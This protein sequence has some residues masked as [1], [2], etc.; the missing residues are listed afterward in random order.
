M[1]LL[2]F[3]QFTL[4]LG[5]ILPESFQISVPDGHQLVQSIENLTKNCD[6]SKNYVGILDAI[7][8]SLDLQVSHSYKWLHSN[9]QF[10]FQ[11][12]ATERAGAAGV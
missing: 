12:E 10:S 5:N 8:H 3:V 6:Q 9:F 4:L 11:L 7:H 2:Q 1:F